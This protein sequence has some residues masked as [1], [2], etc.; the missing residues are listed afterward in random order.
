MASVKIVT[1]HVQGNLDCYLLVNGPAFAVVCGKYCSEVF[2]ATDAQAIYST[3]TGFEM[4]KL[5]AKLKEGMHV[6]AVKRIVP[7]LCENAVVNAGEY[8]EYQLLKLQASANPINTWPVSI[9][10]NG[11]MIELPIGVLDDIMAYLNSQGLEKP[12]SVG[13]Y[14]EIQFV[15]QLP[16]LEDE[17]N[18]PEEHIAFVLTKTDGDKATDSAWKFNGEKWVE[19]SDVPR[20]AD[21]TDAE[22]IPDSEVKEEAPAN[23]GA[24]DQATVEVWD[25]A[26]A[27]KVNVV[28]AEEVTMV[29]S[30]LVDGMA[31]IKV[32]G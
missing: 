16:S 8:V 23:I 22:T 30:T 5:V 17:D 20:E 9:M 29:N 27:E 28:A 32:V 2:S 11:D 13:K 14:T 26:M 6:P 24:A 7:V 15:P 3:M 10:N 12:Y 21:P 4:A 19:V 31:V 1:T 25:K 18:L